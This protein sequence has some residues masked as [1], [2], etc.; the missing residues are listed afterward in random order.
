MAKEAKVVLIIVEGPSDE[1]ALSVLEKLLST[2]QVKFFVVHGDITTKKGVSAGTA[3]GEMKEYLDYYLSCSKLKQSDILQI[4]HIVDMDGAYVSDDVIRYNENVD[5]P[6]YF[7]DKIETN[8]V[9]DLKETHCQKKSVLDKLSTTPFINKSVPYSIYYFSCNLEHVFHN[10]LEDFSDDEKEELA[11]EV[12]DRYH[13][14]LKS[15]ID[16]LK[17]SSFSVQQDYVNSWKFIKEGLNSLNRYSNVHLIFE[18]IRESQQNYSED[19]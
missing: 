8:K 16:F 14:D 18:K 1:T 10:R 7:V 11:N 19:N 15:F 5:H 12:D 9:N 4:I 2:Q 3:R 13:D 6:I 17:N